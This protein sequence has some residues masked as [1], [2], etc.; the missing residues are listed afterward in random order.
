MRPRPGLV[1]IVVPAKNE[2]PAI[3]RTLRGLPV[4]TLRAAG[5]TVETVVVDGRSRDGTDDIARRHGARV[6]RDG[7]AGKG[8][9][10]RQARG[11]FHGEFIVMIDADGSYAPDAIPRVVDAMARGGADVVMGDR[12]PQPGS[13]SG[14]HRVGNR[15]LSMQA[16]L[17]YGTA[18][19]DVCTGL[20]GF[21]HEAL[22]GLPLR[23]TGF[24]LEAE[25]FA[26]STRLGLRIAHVPVDYLPRQGV[27]KLSASRDGMRIG[28]T[29]LRSRFIPLEPQRPAVTEVRA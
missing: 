16:T 24:E 3:G 28:W 25:L 29:L 18:C 23:S 26:T 8:L 6:I 1:T 14:L 20:W 5:Y 10:V 22:R 11:A 4:G 9:A 2:A 17:L 27:A 21:R 15:L 7:G 19:R 12:R 13:M